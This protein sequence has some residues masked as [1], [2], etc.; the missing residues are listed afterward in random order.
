MIEN[1]FATAIALSDSQR[2]DAALCPFCGASPWQVVIGIA[3]QACDGC[4]ETAEL[5]MAVCECGAT[6]PDAPGGATGA[7]AAWNKRTSAPTSPVRINT[8]PRRTQG[9]SHD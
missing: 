4:G 2:A 1:N 5:S 9:A 6:G 3:E 7:V 8:Q